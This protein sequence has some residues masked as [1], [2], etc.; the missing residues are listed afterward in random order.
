V[1][2]WPAGEQ[3]SMNTARPIVGPFAWC[4]LGLAL[5]CG[6]VGL[7]ARLPLLIIVAVI[8]AGCAVSSVIVRLRRY[9][10]EDIERERFL[11]ETLMD[12]IPD[13]IYFKDCESRFIRINSAMA[14]VFKLKEPRDAI[15][16]SDFDFFLPEHARQAFEDEQ[17]IIRSGQP[18][19]NREE[20]ETWPDGTVTWVSTTKVAIR[21]KKDHIV[22]TFGISRDITGRKQAEAALAKSAQELARSNREL[23]QFAYVASHDLQEPLRM[24]ASYL[25]L[26]DRRY[27]ETLDPNGREFLAFA[28]DGA[29]RLQNLIHD[30]LLYSR[31]GREGE[32]FAWTNCEESLARA[33]VNLKFSIEESH[34]RITH[35]PLPRIMADSTELTQLLQ[36]LIGNAIKFRGEHAPEIHIAVELRKAPQAGKVSASSPREEWVFAI[37]DNGIGIEPQYFERIF[38]VFQRL[39][40]RD[41]FPGTGIGLALCKRI[42][43]RHGGRIWVESQPGKGTTFWFTIPQT[44]T[45]A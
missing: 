20:K 38:V 44:N 41:E 12:H 11:V 40:T 27:K 1:A 29:K 33:L 10:Q 17:A 37:T 35:G 34:A 21:D 18:L 3:G 7:A 28:V 23:E 15:G 43:E 26:L 8:P 2:G 42:I 22:G 5:I 19:V 14:R 13:H 16:K 24:I 32:T 36:N 30:L 6:A 39:H 9:A 4:A 45:P 25:Q 31:V